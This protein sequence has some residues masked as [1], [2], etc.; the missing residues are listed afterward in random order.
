VVSSSSRD[1]LG[2]QSFVVGGSG[3]FGVPSAAGVT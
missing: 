1:Q 2:L 3:I